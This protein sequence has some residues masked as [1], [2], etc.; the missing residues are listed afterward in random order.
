MG[1]GGFVLVVG[2][3]GA[4]KDT[5]LRLAR[6]ALAGEPRYVFPRRL[7]T[8]PPSVHE[9]NE[10]IGEAEFAAGEAEGRFALSWRA[11]DLGYALPAAT[12]S[13]ARDGHVV[14]CNVSRRVVDEARRRL[15]AVTVVEVTAPPGVL[16]ARLAARGRPEDGDLAAR[17]AR[18]APVAADCLV[19][20]DRAP[21]AGAERLLAH[22]RAR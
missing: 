4:G 10:A 11:H 6:E 5:L 15:P 20:N 14:V 19:V 16:A 12:A 18:S 22:L 2:P 21:E 3:S 7:V 9:D 1:T 17:L 8:R 13:L